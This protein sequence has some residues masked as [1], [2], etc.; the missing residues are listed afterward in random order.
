MLNQKTMENRKPG[1]IISFAD[2]KRERDDQKE[3]EEA[4]LKLLKALFPGD[5]DTMTGGTH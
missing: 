4:E 3:A 2:A 1:Q 5:F